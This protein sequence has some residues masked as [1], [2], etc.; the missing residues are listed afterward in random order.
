MAVGVSERA[1]DTPGA[2]DDGRLVIGL[3][4]G[5]IASYHEREEIEALV[6]GHYLGVKPQAAELALDRR[7]SEGLPPVGGLGNDPDAGLVLTQYT[8]RGTMRGGL[9]EPF[10]LADPRDRR[11]MVVM[12]GLGEPGRFGSGELAVVAREVCWAL[13]HA[14]I[15][16]AATVVI[17]AGNGNLDSERAIDAWLRGIG[18]AFS[19]SPANGRRLRRLTFVEKDARRLGALNRALERV[20]EDLEGH[21]VYLPIDPALLEKAR[22]EARDEVMRNFEDDWSGA[23]TTTHDDAPTRI[24][25]GQWGRKYRFGAITASAAIPEREIPINPVVVEQANQD[26]ATASDAE[27][28]YQRGRFLGKLLLPDDLR[29]HLVGEAPVVLLLDS[30][31]A[32]IHWELITEGLVAPGQAKEEPLGLRRGLTRQLRTGFAPPPEP[33]PPPQR[34]LRVLVVA[35]PA[36]EERLE[37]AAKEG[38]AV[39][40]LFEDYGKVAPAAAGVE[41]VS[42]IGPEQATI[43]EVLSRLLLERFHV[44]HFAGHCQFD[45]A[46]PERTGWLF[47]K[48]Q[49]LAADELNRVDRVPEFVFSNACESGLT[50]DRSTERSAA[51][52]PTFA[53]SFF[54]RGV[55]NFVCTAWP[56]D[57]QAALSFAKELYGHLLGLGDASP[58]PMHRA[59]QQARQKISET[60][61][62]ASSWGAYQHYG[63]PYFRLLS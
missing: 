56:V 63:D 39:A 35:D 59:M 37:G 17:G 1:D 51:L 62:G 6:V 47:S 20:A 13:G 22:C 31:A 40:T 28:R 44:L 12:M 15:Q 30:S 53:E 3:E 45:E 61:R 46:D 32:R 55:G 42:L 41:V 24:T 4:W 54:A 19:E 34:V 27:R 25:V 8:Q 21:A 23:A 52:A 43:T 18:M 14:G 2:P 49:F 9:G 7:I 36:A 50:P 29:P 48:D 58:L 26:L 11:R 5:D 10:L 57:D 33:P 16:R 38:E 60:G